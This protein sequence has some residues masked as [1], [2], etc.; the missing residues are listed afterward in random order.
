MQCLLPSFKASLQ[1]CIPSCLEKISMTQVIF[2]NLKS[3][4][5]VLFLSRRINRLH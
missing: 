5:S 4:W 2:C 1:N 3:L